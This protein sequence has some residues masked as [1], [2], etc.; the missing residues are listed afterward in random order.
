MRHFI[1]VFMVIAVAACSAHDEQDAVDRTILTN[2]DG[3]CELRA[4]TPEE[5]HELRIA[6]AKS[7]KGRG[8]VFTA[9]L[10]I[11][12]DHCGPITCGAGPD[13]LARQAKGL[14]ACIPPT[15]IP[16]GC[17]IPRQAWD[18]QWKIIKP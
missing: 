8:P 16:H 3:T 6:H 7:C 1:P 15:E 2:P 13:D 9:L 18:G 17:E 4:L 10:D 11:E 12:S 14:V 5:P